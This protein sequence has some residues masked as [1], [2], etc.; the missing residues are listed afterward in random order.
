MSPDFKI[1]S[2][3]DR[4]SPEIYGASKSSIIQ[5]TKYYAVL[6]AKRNINVNCISPGGLLNKSYSLMD[7]SQDIKNEF[8]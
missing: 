2:K 8:L 6:L 5:L 7:L 3:G 1:Y 4:F